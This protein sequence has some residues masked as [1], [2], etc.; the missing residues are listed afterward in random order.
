M[1]KIAQKMGCSQS[2]NITRNPENCNITEPPVKKLTQ[3]PISVYLCQVLTVY[4]VW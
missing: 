1:G 3:Q 2:P 4:E